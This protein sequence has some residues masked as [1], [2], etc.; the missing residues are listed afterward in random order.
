[1]ATKKKTKQ[2][3]QGPVSFK[4][5]QKG[6]QVI[7]EITCDPL[8]M[9]NL[10]FILEEVYAVVVHM[11]SDYSK[12][13]GFLQGNVDSL[14]IN[15]DSINSNFLRIETE[16]FKLKNKPWWRRFLGL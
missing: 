10:L 9:K 12:K 15:Q 6:S 5:Y 16:L 7:A 4:T 13:I 2:E 11:N 1:M 14:K 3:N 8:N